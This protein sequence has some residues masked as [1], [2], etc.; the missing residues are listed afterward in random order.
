LQGFDRGAPG[1][2]LAD[3]K[4]ETFIP[5]EVFLPALFAGMKQLNKL[6]RN[7]IA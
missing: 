6:M 1:G 5:G 3:D 7:G 2:R 4:L